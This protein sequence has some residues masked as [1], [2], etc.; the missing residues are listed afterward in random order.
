MFNNQVS[1]FIPSCDK[2]SDVWN[3][4]FALLFKYWQN[5]PLPI[6]LCSN[7]IVYPDPRVKTI[8]VGEDISWAS[9]CKRCLKQIDTQY[10]ILLQ[11][12]FL[13]QKYVDTQKIKELLCFMGKKQTACLRL[14]PSPP[15]NK[16]IKDREEVGEIAIGARYRVS[17]QAAIWDKY[18]LY[19]LLKEGE[20]PWDMEEKGSQ[21]SN[22]INKPFLSVI[23]DPAVPLPIDYFST[24]VVGGIWAR[25]AVKLLN[26]ENI[27]IDKTVRPIESIFRELKREKYYPIR[28][29]VGKILRKLAIIPQ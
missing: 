20:S 2:Y 1:I 12:D 22:Y 11:E 5:C 21:R 17:L 15:P 6:H 14:Y 4:F 23:R 27:K 10:I 3:P 8:L 26:K 13:I 25:K 18:I 16:K 19:D 7:T 29:K 9:N 24:G 28:S